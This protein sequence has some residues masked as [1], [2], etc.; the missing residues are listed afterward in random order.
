VVSSRG[1]RV[2]WFYLGILSFPNNS[3]SIAVINSFYHHQL[4]PTP[5]HSICHFL[6]SDTRVKMT[7]KP[8]IPSWQR[9]QA[10]TLQSPL[11]SEPETKL[12]S[13]EPEETEPNTTTSDPEESISESIPEEKEESQLGSSLLLEQASKFLEDPAIR[14]A[15]WDKKV[16][17]LESKGVKNEEIEKLRE[18]KHE[19]STINLESEGERAWP[20]VCTL[21]A[22]LRVSQRNSEM[23]MIYVLL[24]PFRLHHNPHHLSP[25]NPNLETCRPS[26]RTLSSSYNHRSRP[27]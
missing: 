26:S 4:L 12:E 23:T 7:D 24:T 8:G 15:P 10:A 11:S 19:E 16:A 22:A 14:D 1:R 17:F 20:R 5:E 3:S 13:Q 25:S 21:Q 6:R 9:A 2:S 27:R 18:P